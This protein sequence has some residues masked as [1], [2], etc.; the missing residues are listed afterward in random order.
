MLHTSRHA[1]HSLS[2]GRFS[3][4]CC[5]H[6][7]SC[8]AQSQHPGMPV[9][10]SKPG[11]PGFRDCARND[12]VEAQRHATPHCHRC[13]PPAMLHT[14]RNAAHLPAILRTSSNTP[15]AP[16]HTA[17]TP[18]SCCAQ[19]Q[20]PERPVERSKPGVP[21]FRDYARNDPV[22]PQRPCSFGRRLT[23]PYFAASAPRWV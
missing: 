11:V 13:A 17:R 16:R 7:L 2:C 23:E 4:P 9:E 14:S 8:C 5:P 22:E 12:P 20:H 15:R 18:L 10:Q 3:P 19:S 6:P 21:G 1:A